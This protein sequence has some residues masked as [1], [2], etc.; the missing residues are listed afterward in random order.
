MPCSGS[1]RLLQARL[2]A[3]TETIIETRKVTKAY[4][5]VPAIKDIDFDLKEGE[6]HS[7]VGE[8][9]A[10]KSTLTKIMAGAVVASSGTMVYRGKEVSF[11]SPSE[12]LNAGIAMVFQ[13][14]SLVPSMTVA[15]NLYLGEEKF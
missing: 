3:M 14:T 7:L 13:E 9:G 10:G 6:I 4:R 2:S 11:A 15:Q 12:A 1:T 5:G 8:N